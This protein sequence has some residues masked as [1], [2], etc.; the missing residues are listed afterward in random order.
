MWTVYGI[1][2]LSGAVLLLTAVGPSV[3]QAPVLAVSAIVAFGTFATA[4]SWLL[5][6]INVFRRCAPRTAALA[7]LWGG[8]AAAGYAL[9]ANNAIHDHLSA[10]G[11]T[12]SWSMFAPLTEE[13]AKDV[14][15]A[16]VLLLAGTRPRTPLDGLV[17]G[18][19][20]GLGFEVV[21]SI[22]R[23]LNNAIASYPPG[24]RDNLGSLAVDVAH[25][26]IRNSWTGHIVLTGI[27]GFGIGLLLTAGER[28]GNRRWA[29]GT[30][31]IAAAAAGHFLWNSHRLGPLYVIGQFAFLALFL[32]LIRVGRNQEA[33]I[34]TPYLRYAPAVV[35][36]AEIAALC[37]RTGR[38]NRQSKARQRALADLA[39]AIANGDA[40]RAHESV[41]ALIGT[42]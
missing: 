23:A 20:V 21:E 10:R 7:L 41:A 32:R 40:Q 19:F 25:E 2:V 24:Q 9:L 5:S 13:P 14:G 37:S 42:A 34:Y 8:F 31:L 11:P 28:F 17:A 33:A 39:A 3:T 36:P 4:C 1:G 26:V 27:A 38:K 15:V 12:D 35:A 29:P 16:L 18:S 6:R 22:T 30:A